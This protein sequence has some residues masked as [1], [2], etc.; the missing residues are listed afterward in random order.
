MAAS[1]LIVYVI[2]TCSQEVITRL[3][4]D[5]LYL[6]V[7]FVVYGLFRYLFLVHHR[8]GGGDPSRTL[9]QDWPLLTTVLLWGMT[10]MGIIYAGRLGV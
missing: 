7:P 8:S 5:K 2:Y 3:G 9:L 1:T 6:T 10:S 4:T